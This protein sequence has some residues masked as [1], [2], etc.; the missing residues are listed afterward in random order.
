LNKFDDAIKKKILEEVDNFNNIAIYNNELN[1]KSLNR[2][3]LWLNKCDCA[4]ITAFRY[5]LIDIAN[6]DKTYY[7][8]ND[9]WTDKKIFTHEENREKNKLLKAELLNLKYGVTTVKRVYPEGMNNESSVESFFVVNRFNDPNFLNNLLSLAEYFNQD[10]I[11]YKPKDKTYGYLIGTNG[12]TYPGYHKKGDESKLKPGSASNFMSRIGNKAFSFIP[13]NALKVNNR[14]EGIENTD[15]PQRYWT[16]YE[17]TSFKDRKRSRVQEATDFWKS[18]C[19]RR[20][21]VLEEMEPRGRWAMGD[22]I[23]MNLR[24]ARNKPKLLK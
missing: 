15:A 24:N 18:I 3:M 23:N 17:G 11:Y 20:M 5:K 22:Y 6:P 13:N 1:E 10:S 12:A 8:P 16:D 9:N 21:E 19:V 7:G 14:K 4:F 2:M